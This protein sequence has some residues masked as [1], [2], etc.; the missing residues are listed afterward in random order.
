MKKSFLLL[1][2]LVASCASNKPIQDN[3]NEVQLN[4]T[5]AQAISQKPIVP[6]LDKVYFGF[7]KCK[8]HIFWC[9]V[10]ELCCI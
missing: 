7:D 3:A 2:L 1:P 4:A 9:C 10:F 5:Q 6:Y 8:L